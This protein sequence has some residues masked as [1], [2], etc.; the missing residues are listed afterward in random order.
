MPNVPGSL[1]YPDPSAMCS[2]IHS[3]KQR[4]L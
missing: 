2:I 1:I 3:F 4:Y